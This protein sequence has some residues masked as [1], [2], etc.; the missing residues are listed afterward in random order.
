M[1]YFCYLLLLVPILSFSQTG[2]LD[3]KDGNIYWQKI[4]E[5][6]LSKEEIRAIIKSNATLNPLFENFSGISN[7]A[8]IKCKEEDLPNYMANPFQ[9][10]A[11]VEF[12]NNRYRVT[13]SDIKIIP[14]T[15]KIDDYSNNIQNNTPRDLEDYQLKNGAFRTFR[16]YA[17]NAR[18]CLMNYFNDLFDF[19]LDSADLDW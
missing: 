1:K 11:L 5:T 3:L 12:K 19:K 6:D 7:P 10:F 4:Y 18:I 9:F 15:L 13:I 17:S 8:R 14:R 16:S 2:A